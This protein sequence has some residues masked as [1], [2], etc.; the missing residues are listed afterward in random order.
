VDWQDDWPIQRQ[1]WKGGWIHRVEEGPGK[2]ERET[3][4]R[5]VDSPSLV[6]VWLQGYAAAEKKL[7][8]G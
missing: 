4:L 1:A 7:K 3:I 8:Q 6:S 2:P 5:L